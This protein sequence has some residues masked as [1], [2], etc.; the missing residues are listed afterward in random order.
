MPQNA[1]KTA[2]SIRIPHLANILSARDLAENAGPGVQLTN[3]AFKERS[4]SMQNDPGFMKLSSR[5]NSDSDFR[6]RVNDSLTA[7]GSGMGLKM[8]YHNINK[9]EPA[10]EQ[11]MTL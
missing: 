10:V 1:S 3:K 4:E 2:R 5:Y 9:E 8:A 11:T 7:D 6:G